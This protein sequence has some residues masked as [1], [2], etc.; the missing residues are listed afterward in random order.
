MLGEQLFIKHLSPLIDSI[1][2]RALEEKRRELL[3]AIDVFVTAQGQTVTTYCPAFTV[4]PAIRDEQ[5]DGGGNY[6]KLRADHQ[7]MREAEVLAQ[8]NTYD[9][10]I[11]LLAREDAGNS[12]FNWARVLEKLA[13]LLAASQVR[14]IA[15]SK[16]DTRRNELFYSTLSGLALQLDDRPLARQLADQAVEASSATGW[17]KGYDG[18]TRLQAFEAMKRIDPAQTMRRAFDVFGHDLATASTPGFYIEDLDEILPVLTEN[19]AIEMIWDEVFGYLERLFANSQPLTD[20]PDLVP[21]TESIETVLVDL[22]GYLARMPVPAINR[23]A[24]ALLATL[25]TRNHD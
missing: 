10:L 9:D 18:G 7:Q 22:V 17:V 20:L 13:P 8:V 5:S 4:P 23:S 24:R 21:G 6:L 19:F 12:Y 25:A 16:T 1:N 14:T 3:R 11:A 15:D 2:L